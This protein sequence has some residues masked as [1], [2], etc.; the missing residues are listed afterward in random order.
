MYNNFYL[1]L[2]YWYNLKKK[3]ITFTVIILYTPTPGY[4]QSFYFYEF[5]YS[6][7]LI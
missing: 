4:Q 6:E 7:Y 5:I 2:K 1:V 3:H